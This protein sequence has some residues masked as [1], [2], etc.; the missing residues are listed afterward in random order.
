[1]LLG[2]TVLVHDPVG[3]LALGSTAPVENQGLLHPN[4][5]AI[6]ARLAGLDGTVLARGFPVA[7]VGGPVRTMPIW[8]LPITRTEEEPLR[9]ARLYHRQT[10]LFSSYITQNKST[11]LEECQQKK[12]KKKESSALRNCQMWVFGIGND[13][14]LIH[15]R[16]KDQSR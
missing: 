13:P 6:G 7:S 4:R 11:S 2:G 8:V 10:F 5:G 3:A 12:K 15:R 14:F 1:V 16:I 9:I